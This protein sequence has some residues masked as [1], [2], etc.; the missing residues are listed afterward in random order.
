MDTKNILEKIKKEGEETRNH[1]DVVVEKL[2]D[3][4]KILA[5]KL[6]YNTESI[7]NHGSRLE[8]IESRLGGIEGA[9][10]IS[11]PNPQS[12]SQRAAQLMNSALLKKN[13]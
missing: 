1:F 7:N 9:I 3:N 8:K 5:E 4:I 6:S 2:E 11:P 13:N 12:D 10:R